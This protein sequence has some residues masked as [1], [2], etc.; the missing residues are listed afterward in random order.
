MLMNAFLGL[1]SSLAGMAPELHALGTGR[2][3]TL[4]DPPAGENDS[5]EG[6]RPNAYDLYDDYLQQMEESLVSRQVNTSNT[7]V[8]HATPYAKL[9]SR[10]VLRLVLSFVSVALELNAY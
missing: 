10:L 4:S 2:P 1:R 9:I 6:L 5:T 8:S 3:R 7:S